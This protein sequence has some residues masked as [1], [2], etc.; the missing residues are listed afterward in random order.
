MNVH[1]KIVSTL[2]LAVL[3]LCLTGAESGPQRIS[4]VELRSKFILIGQLEQRLGTFMNIEGKVHAEPI[5][6]ASPFDV[7]TVDGVKLAKPLVIEVQWLRPIPADT[8]CV[9]RGYETGGMSGAPYD[10]LG[11]NQREPAFVYQFATWFVV[12]E[13]KE[14]ATQERAK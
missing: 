8:R 5:K 13:V 11:K 14:P 12:T 1:S 7:D 4:V 10:P 3:A 6:M 2:A 9:L